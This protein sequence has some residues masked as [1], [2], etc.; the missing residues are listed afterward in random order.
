VVGRTPEPVWTRWRNYWDFKSDPSVV[1]PVASRYTDY[2]I[3]AHI[4]ASVQLENRIISRESQGDLSE[5]EL[6]DGKTPV[7]K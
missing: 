4:T 5:D 7:V 3:P 1:Q 6:I 2:A